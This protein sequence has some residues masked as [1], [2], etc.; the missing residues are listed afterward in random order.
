MTW[1]R[2]LRAGAVAG[3]VACAACSGPGVPVAPGPVPAPDIPPLA[4]PRFDDP[5]EAPRPLP[6]SDAGELDEILA[7]P[8]ATHPD[9]DGRARYWEEVYAVRQ[10]RGFP[11]FL[12]RMAAFEHLVDSVLTAE[13]LPR[14]LRYLPIIESGYRPAAVSSASAVGLWQFMA[15]VARGFGMRVTPLVDERR[16]PVRS[17]VTAARYLAELRQRFDSWF[18]ALAAY[19][20]GPYRVE[21]L[22]RDHA[23]LAPLGDSLFTVIAPH[24]PRE[25][26]D[27][28]P[29]LLAVARVGEHPERYGLT[30]P[31]ERQA[32]YRFDEV[33]VP[34][35]TSFDVVAEAAGVDEAVVRALNPHVLRGVTPRGVATAVRIPPGTA[36]RFRVAYAEVPPDR[37]VTVAEHV[38]RSGETL[39]GIASSYGIRTAELEA[40]NPG[41][42][43]RR[44]QIGQRL[45][46]PLVPGAAAVI[47][48]VQG[49][50]AG[51]NG[52]Y[53][54]RP[55]DSLW[56][57]ARRHGTTVGAL[58][59]WNG[60]SAH[61][62]LQPGDRLRVRGSG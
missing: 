2:M 27:F 39:S 38:V 1:W 26:R 46:V 48:G 49:A 50:S 7:S 18:L 35:A 62:V 41:V 42:R 60:L 58:R 31:V 28:I 55:G 37:R 9:V 43:P 33:E 21:R 54:V 32:A 11:V 24:L 44:L 20:G 53:V 57:I 8:W 16:D 22:L 34:D 47:A 36:E 59:A 6:P 3:L 25:T 12:D 52:V 56:T 30:P 45:M 61:A 17:T 29:K 40:A 51:E 4:A 23:P 5:V 19:N 14:S 10:G 13:G 15:P